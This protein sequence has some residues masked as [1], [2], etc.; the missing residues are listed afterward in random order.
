MR[1]RF[2]QISAGEYAKILYSNFGRS[3]VERELK[4]FLDLN[5]IPRCGGGIGFNRMIR[6]LK[7]AGILKSP[8]QQKTE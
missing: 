6:A 4:T 3:R 5:F 7:M 8:E 1:A 2:N